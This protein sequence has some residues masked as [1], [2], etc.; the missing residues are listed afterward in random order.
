MPG[1]ACAI[2]AERTRRGAAPAGVEP[3]RFGADLRTDLGQYLARGDEPG[4]ALLF[5]A[6]AGL[7]GPSHASAGA[8]SLRRGEPSWRRCDGSVR[9]Q[10]GAG[11]AAR[12]NARLRA[13]TVCGNRK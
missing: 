3:R 7:G 5:A 13:L 12:L 1:S 6:C 10:C 2:R 4:T 11:D 9:P 8:V